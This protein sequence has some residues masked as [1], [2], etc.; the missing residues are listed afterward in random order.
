MYVAMMQCLS[1]LIKLV[2]NIGDQYVPFITG[3]GVTKA[4]M[5][6]FMK[7]ETFEE[8]QEGR[9]TGLNGRTVTVKGSRKKS[10]RIIYR[11]SVT[12]KSG[13]YNA[14]GM[15]HFS[16]TKNKTLTES[17]YEY[18]FQLSQKRLKEEDAAQG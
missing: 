9:Y 13:H 17:C 14:M 6:L 5:M 2:E 15:K 1:R 12:G 18:L 7:N 3:P 4:A 8:V 11:E 10:N 16:S